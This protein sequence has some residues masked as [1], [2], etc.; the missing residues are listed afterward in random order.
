MRYYLIGLDKEGYE[1]P[2]F[3][4]LV[5]DG[6]K[7]VCGMRGAFQGR[8]ADTGWWREYMERHGGIADHDWILGEW[9][10][11]LEDM[12]ELPADKRERFIDRCALHTPDILITG[13]DP[14]DAPTLHEAAGHLLRHVVHEP[15]EGDAA[16]AVYQAA[17]IAGATVSRYVDIEVSDGRGIKPD[18]VVEHTPHSHTAAQEGMTMARS[19]VAVRARTRV[20]AVYLCRDEMD[21]TRAGDAAKKM[22]S[23]HEADF[24]WRIIALTPLGA[25]W[26][27]PSPDVVVVPVGSSVYAA[28]EMAGLFE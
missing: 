15:F 22:G 4:F 11:W 13:P 8:Q 23:N 12:C 5:E 1:A 17:R 3:A 2:P 18:F 28:Y 7:A 25:D 14:I 27:N 21:L 16:Q 6:D 24:D 9:Q 20:T 10:D 26:Q 19:F